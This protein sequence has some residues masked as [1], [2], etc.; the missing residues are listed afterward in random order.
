MNN[1]NKIIILFSFLIVIFG[2]LIISNFSLNSNLIENLENNNSNNKCSWEETSSPVCK[3]LDDRVKIMCGDNILNDYGP[4]NDRSLADCNNNLSIHKNTSNPMYGG[5]CCP[6]GKRY[7]D[8]KKPNSLAESEPQSIPNPESQQQTP[9]QPQT[10]SQINSQIDSDNES[11]IESNSCNNSCVI[12][13]DDCTQATKNENG[14]HKFINSFKCSWSNMFKFN[15]DN[16][17]QNI[18]TQCSKCNNINNVKFNKKNNTY[19]FVFNNKNIILSEG[20]YM[21][22]KGIV[23][24]IKK[25]K[26]IPSLERDETLPID[27]LNELSGDNYNNFDKS[28]NNSINNI[29]NRQN[30]NTGRNN[31]EI[32]KQ[33]R[34]HVG[35][36]FNNY[37]GE[38]FKS[39][40]DNRNIG[41]N[42]NTTQHDNIGYINLDS[43]ISNLVNAN[44]NNRLINDNPF[45]GQQMCYNNTNGLPINCPRPYDYK[46]P[47]KF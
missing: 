36:L 30:R 13:F 20:Y 44:S 10:Q 23:K 42:L 24:Q 38:L 43:K 16:P 29:Q 6:N 27:T 18:R 19:E 32:E 22:N 7:F 14:I 4:V 11:K 33:I 31:S 47:M 35:D 25:Q 26:S 17:D 46:P 28:D 3:I 40:T 45:T 21:D 12:S 39:S 34:E 8:I 37:I 9:I 1:K 15:S 41:S 2:I 5:R